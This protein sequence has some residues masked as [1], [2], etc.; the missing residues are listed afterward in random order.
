M[1]R[2]IGGDPRGCR[3]PG[4]YWLDGGADV[5]ETP[6]TPFVDQPDARPVRPIEHW[7]RPTPGSQL[8]S[9]T[10]YDF[11]T[12]ITDQEGATLEVEADLATMASARRWRRYDSRAAAR[13]SEP[14]CT[15]AR[16][17]SITRADHERTGCALVVSQW[18]PRHRQPAGS[19]AQSEHKMA[20]P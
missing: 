16:S 20:R 14:C 4:P 18:S 17:E 9:F 11:H 2:L 12:F 10:L 13:G 3:T 19:G 15:M 5:A 1:R 7:E 8:A 6:Y